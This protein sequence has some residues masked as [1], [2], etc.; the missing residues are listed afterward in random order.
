VNDLSVRLELQADCYAGVWG[1]STAQRN[2]LEQGDVEEGLN[3]AASIGDD[4]IQRMSGSRVAPERFTHGSSAQRVS[5]FK[6]G[7]DTGD[8]K[9]CNT[10]Q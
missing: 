6:R 5:W 8:I 9:A 7:M 4:R 2:I 10:F 1:H 3:A